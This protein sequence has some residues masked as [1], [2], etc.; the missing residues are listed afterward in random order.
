MTGL[1]AL[2]HA[3]HGAFAHAGHGGDA[4]WTVALPLALVLVVGYVVAAA[5]VRPRWRVSRSAS[6]L[7]GCALI[8]LAGMP[9]IGSPDDPHMHIASHLL[10]GMFA[11]LGLV[12]AA[13]VT[14]L[15]RVASPAVR[16][17]TVRLLRSRYV[18]VVGHPVSALVLTVGGLAA[19]MLGPLVAAGPAVHQALQLHYVAAG[20][21]LT[22]ALVGP[23]PSPHRARMSTRVAVLVVAAAGHAILAKHLYA[24]AESMAGPLGT[25]PRT[26]ESA[27]ML[28]YYGADVAELLLAVVLFGS[29]YARRGRRF[30]RPGRSKPDPERAVP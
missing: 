16:W 15:L 28:M 18:R 4:G 8:A 21:L 17:R 5:R 26:V 27:A 2:A 3:G 6:W 23:D 12:L 14:L 7:A 19:V 20:C 11:P 1:P 24:S 22:W 25:D 30:V 13:P 10:L 29:W 9:P